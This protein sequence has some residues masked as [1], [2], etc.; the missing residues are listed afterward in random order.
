[1]IT[2]RQKR[3]LSEILEWKP[4]PEDKLIYFRERLRGRLHSAILRAYVARS[5]ERG[6]KRKDLAARIHRTQAQITRWLSTASNLTL[7]SISDLMVGLA[8]DFDEF[9]FTRI[10]ETIAPAS[11]GMSAV[12]KTTEG[13]LPPVVEAAER[14]AAPFRAIEEVTGIFKATATSGMI[15][16]LKPAK[17]LKAFATASRTSGIARYFIS[18]E[19]QAP[20][21]TR[22]PIAVASQP[23][24]QGASV[25]DLHLNQAPLGE[26]PYAA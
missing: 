16:Y 3:F 18:E 5:K 25:I 22:S 13:I 15:E 1:M 20:L 7:D 14:I 23:A 10:E 2:F 11:A 6:L 24:T 21:E 9:P 26:L 17:E 4:I 8:M 12:I 19:E